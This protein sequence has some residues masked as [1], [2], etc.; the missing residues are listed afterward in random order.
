MGW[1]CCLGETIK[2]HIAVLWKMG[3]V[4]RAYSG[5]GN[6]SVL[7]IVPTL[8]CIYNIAVVAGVGRIFL[9]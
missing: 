8:F 4:C 1:N 3:L 9:R 5:S 2:Y 7:R 6:N